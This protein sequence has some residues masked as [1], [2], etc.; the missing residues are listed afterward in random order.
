M[1]YG[2][3]VAALQYD[4][5]NVAIFLLFPPSRPIS[6]LEVLNYSIHSS[7]GFSASYTAGNVRVNC[8]TDQ[9]SRWSSASNDQNQFLILEISEE[10]AAAALAGQPNS[11]EQAAGCGMALLESI[12]F[13][14][15][16]KGNK[17]VCHTVLYYAFY[18]MCFILFLLY[19][20]FYIIH[21]VLL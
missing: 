20:S 9:A 11:V 15:F 4:N 2:K 21:F 18:I 3:T 10:E 6:F 14:K 7:S 17:C 5:N 1:Q 16:H 12:G 19:Y 13:G 8:P